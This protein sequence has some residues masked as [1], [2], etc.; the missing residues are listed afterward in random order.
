MQSHYHIHYL[1]KTLPVLQTYL[2][3]LKRSSERLQ[4]RN[5]L[6]YS[7]HLTHFLAQIVVTVTLVGFSVCI[8]MIVM[9]VLV[10]FG[11]GLLRVVIRKRLVQVLDDDLIVF[12]CA[13]LDHKFVVLISELYRVERFIL[14]LVNVI[15]SQY[16][17]L[18]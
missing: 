10:V 8:I 14:I 9:I 15:K 12:D 17:S 5:L 3:K 18:Q 1:E 4:L 11:T 6:T 7:C 13:I 2:A 16:L